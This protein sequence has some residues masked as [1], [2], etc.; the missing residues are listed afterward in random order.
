MTTSSLTLRFLFLTAIAVT[1]MYSYRAVAYDAK[2]SATESLCNS[3][4]SEYKHLQFQKSAYN[5]K[6]ETEAAAFIDA[7]FDYQRAMMICSS[8]RG[9]QNF[10]LN[11]TE[12]AFESCATSCSEYN[13]RG[14]NPDVGNLITSTVCHAFMKAHC[15]PK[16]PV[17][18]DIS[19]NPHLEAT[20][21]QCESQASETETMCSTA[22]GDTSNTV[23]HM[24]DQG[25]QLAQQS[26]LDAC[27]SIARS[28][29]TIQSG[30]SGVKM[31]CA[32]IYDQCRSTCSA[33]STE[34]D[35]TTGIDPQQK[36]T[37]KTRL[38]NAT[39]QCNRAQDHLRTLDQGLA[40]MQDSLARSSQC[41]AQLSA[42][43][44]AP[45]TY[46]QCKSNP[47]LKGCEYYF[48]ATDC[49]N[50]QTASSNLVCVCQ[51]TPNDPRCS[52]LNVPGSG[53]VSGGSSVGSSSGGGAGA[54]VTGGFGGGGFGTAGDEVMAYGGEGSPY[55]PPNK[56][57]AGGY[58]GGN[59]PASLNA[60]HERQQ[61]QAQGSN[62]NTNVTSKRRGGGLLPL[63]GQRG[64]GGSGNNPGAA[65]DPNSPN[66]QNA[67][68][69]VDLSK[70]LPGREMDPKRRISSTNGPDGIT[71]PFSDNFKKVNARFVVLGHSLK[72]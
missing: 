52:G 54:D 47:S 53:K 19:S 46:D 6:S 21:S 22:P 28:A 30:L 1:N 23:R 41:A 61:P 62:I 68:R 31:A 32:G 57:N 5:G 59:L 36:Q 13:S 64:A 26:S 45:P 42:E 56:P 17:G 39:L 18:D 34:L 70:F 11:T 4:E 9:Y 33:A 2:F 50:P 7:T 15:G 44:F 29:S 67:R 51:S 63:F 66:A 10:T 65:L 16:N 27:S 55:G 3:I 12:R 60:P 38:R 43:G 24:I 48:S 71:G 40:Q 69:G 20:I 25:S 49:S 72:P 37:F 35:G 58:G 14:L 8:V